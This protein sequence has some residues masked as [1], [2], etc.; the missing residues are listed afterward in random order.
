MYLINYLILV[1]EKIQLLEEEAKFKTQSGEKDTNI[2]F[3]KTKI[4][5]VGIS[6]DYE[7]DLDMENEIDTQLNKAIELLK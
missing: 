2:Q 1:I 4:N 5:K 6:P 3:V 7:I